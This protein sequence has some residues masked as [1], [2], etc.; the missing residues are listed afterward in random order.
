MLP[1]L[2]VVRANTKY[3]SAAKERRALNAKN[4]MPETV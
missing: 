1:I 4:A 2:V 3:S